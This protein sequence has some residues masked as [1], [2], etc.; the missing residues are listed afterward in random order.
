MTSESRAFRSPAEP[1]E[2]NLSCHVKQG[3]PFVLLLPAMPGATSS[4]ALVTSRFLLV[5]GATSSD[6]LVTS[7]FLLLTVVPGATSSDALVTTSFLLLTVMPGA[8]SE[9][10]M[11]VVTS[12]YS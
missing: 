3:G 10:A 6:A 8:T 5:P 11:L 4:D 1:R 9:V 2:A 7:S 12:C